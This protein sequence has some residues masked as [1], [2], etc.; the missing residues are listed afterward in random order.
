MDV[1]DNPEQIARR[2]YE[3]FARGDVSL[4][5]DLVDPDLEWTF[6]DPSVP[7]PEP[8]V[9][10][11][12]DQLAYWMARDSGWRRSAELEEVIANGNRVLVV[13]RSA[14]IDQLRARSTGDRNFHVLTIRDGK[15]ATLRACRNRSEALGFVTAD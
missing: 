13:T 14:G 9:C 11:G 1:M 6:L 12:R 4:V 2:A 15:I 3:A 8:A 7:D 10:H 5:L